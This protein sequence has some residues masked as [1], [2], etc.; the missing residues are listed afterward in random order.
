[1]HPDDL[2]S[3]KEV[4][5]KSMAHDSGIYF[6]EHRLRAKNGDWR[7]GVSRGLIVS[8][9]DSGKPLR[10]IGTFSDITE[11]KNNLLKLQKSEINLVDKT[12]RLEN[13][14]RQ[15]VT[16]QEAE[17]SRVAI[18]LHDELGQSLTAIK[19][20]LQMFARQLPKDANDPSAEC[21]RIV[22]VALQQVRSMV[23]ALRPAV[24]DDLGLQPALRWLTEQSSSR[25]GLSVVFTTKL[26]PNRYNKE[27]ETTYFRVAQEALTNISR[28]AQA[29]HVFVEL[30]Q[31]GQ[32]LELLVQDD[33]VGYDLSDAHARAMAGGSLGVLGMRER[34][35]LLGGELLI[36]TSPGNGCTVRL[37]YLLNSNGA[38]A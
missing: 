36:E 1:V 25:L 17:R 18:E 22:D 24:L 13:V 4:M 16:A 21:I 2:E 32:L 27:V 3:V 14:S 10:M 35:R 8:R 33:G 12:Q 20:N 31:D 29:Q 19:I 9:D 11:E 23:L 37:S 7:W 6:S 38:M 15:L 26:P 5:Q 28:Y 34:A 30:K